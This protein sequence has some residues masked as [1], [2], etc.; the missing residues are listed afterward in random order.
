[1]LTLLG[2]L[3]TRHEAGEPDDDERD[4]PRSCTDDHEELTRACLEG[5]D[6]EHRGSGERC[7]GEERPGRL[8]R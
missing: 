5:G 2:T 1:M 4:E 3:V 6:C 7:R 8:A